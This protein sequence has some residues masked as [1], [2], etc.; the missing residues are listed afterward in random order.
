MNKTFISALTAGALICSA[1]FSVAGSPQDAAYDEN[2]NFVSDSWGKC[3]RTKWM[4]TEN[5]PCAPAPAPA[6]VAAP[7]PAPAPA[8]QPVVQK[9]LLNI[10]FDFDSSKLTEKGSYKLSQLSRLINASSRI[11]DVHIV[12]YAD[13]IGNAAYNQKLSTKR[14]KAVEAYLDQYTKIGA[15]LAEL[16]GEGE[17]ENDS[18]KGTKKNTT[19]VNCLSND[20]R[21]EIKLTYETMQ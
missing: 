5:D 13:K 20:R 9:E 14:A 2:N 15:S 4:D 8:P 21:V 16:R 3:V 17:L 6:P 19:L 11:S 7:A 1:Q 10:Y 12:G 18:C